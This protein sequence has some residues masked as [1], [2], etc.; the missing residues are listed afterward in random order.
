MINVQE[1]PAEADTVDL[2]NQFFRLYSRFHILGF[3]SCSVW[4]IWTQWDH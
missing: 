2:R 3:S 1:P 4:S